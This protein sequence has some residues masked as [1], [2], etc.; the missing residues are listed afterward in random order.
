MSPVDLRN[1]HFLLFKKTPVDLEILQ[2]RLSIVKNGNV[3]CHV[4][5]KFS[6]VLRMVLFRLS[7]LRKGRVALSNVE[8]E[9]PA[10]ADRGSRNESLLCIWQ[11][12]G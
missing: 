12:R 11:Q 10:S 7:N 6:V 3:P 1:V 2:C 8:V 4:C 9:G 5:F